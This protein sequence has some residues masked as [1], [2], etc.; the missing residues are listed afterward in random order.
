MK[1]FFFFFCHGYVFGVYYICNNAIIEQTT[2]KQKTDCYIRIIIIRENNLP[3]L[4]YNFVHN[5][6]LLRW[7]ILAYDIVDKTFENQL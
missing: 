3:I 2:N 5:K 7:G 4:F 1:C 6:L